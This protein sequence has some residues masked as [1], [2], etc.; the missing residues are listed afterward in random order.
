SG[1]FLRGDA[2]MDAR[3]SIS[4]AFMILR[5]LWLGTPLT[6]VAAADVDDSGAVQPI[7][8]LLLLEMLFL[9]HG[10]PPP[11]VG[12]PGTDPT[13]DEG[14]GCR[15]GLAAAPDIL[16]VEFGEDPDGASAGC[17][18]DDGGPDLEFIHFRHG[19]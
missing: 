7:D 8:A 12:K 17:D 10:A 3:T 1:R 11:P 16:P 19:K 18:D 13:P 4:D 6:C 5:Y 15:Q 2:N 9:R 14:T